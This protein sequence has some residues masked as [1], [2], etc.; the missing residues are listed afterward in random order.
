MKIHKSL[1]LAVVIVLISGASC[2][3]GGNKDTSGAGPFIGGFDGLIATFVEDAPPSSGIFQGESF[4]IEVELTNVGETLVSEGDVNINLVGTITGGS[5]SLSGK[6]ASNKGEIYSI[7]DLGGEGG[8]EVVGLG[9]AT[10]TPVLSASYSPSVVAQ[11]CYPYKTKIQLDNLCIPSQDRNPVGNQ[12]CEIDGKVNLIGSGDNSAGPVQVTSFMESKTT[13]SIRV[14]IDINNQGSGEVTPCG[15]NVATDQR[16]LVQVSVPQ[17]A[18]CTFK[19]GESNS[20]IV[21]LRNGHA[22]LYCKRDISNQGPAYLDRFPMTLSYPYM[23]QITK[24]ITINK[25]ES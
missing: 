23:Q 4:P 19:E 5:F 17:N 20:G 9:T 12:E 11:V 6:S 25:I 7:D 14:R 18:A 21:E 24:T 2:Q 1:I 22:V 13:T 15:E 8:Y 10:Y 16:G 3:M